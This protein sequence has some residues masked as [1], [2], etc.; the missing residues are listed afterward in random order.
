MLSTLDILNV[1]EEEK[2]CNIKE[3]AKKLDIPEAQL[4]KILENLSRKDIVQYNAETG[5]VTLPRWIENLD[6]EIEEI[7]PAV[8]TIILP[9]NQELTVQGITI[10]NLA[11]IDLELNITLGAKR[12]EITICRST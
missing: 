1:V 4:S 12:K 5:K 6:R 2:S 8:G 11:D 3:L 7:K 9:K 10:G